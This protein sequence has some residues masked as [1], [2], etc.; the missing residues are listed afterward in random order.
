MA[1][2][3]SHNERAA[4]TWGSGGQHYERLS[5]SVSDALTHV[6]NHIAPQPDERF[7][8]VATGTGLTARLLASRGATVTGTDFAAGLIEA[9][10]AL[11]PPIDFQIADAEALPF[12][13]SS[14]DAVTSTFGVMFVAQPEIAAREKW[15]VSARK[16]GRL[17]LA[18][19]AAEGTVT[20]LFAIIRSYM[21]PPPANPPPSPFEWG[22]SER[23]RDLLGDAFE[24]RFETGTTTLRMQSGESF[25]DLWVNGFGPAEALAA[26]CDP[27]RR[28]PL[29]RDFIEFHG[30]SRRAN[31]IRAGDL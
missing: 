2:I 25:W 29:K 10:K 31:S 1:V 24:L 23:V 11:A 28:G 17:G 26:S 13:D 9:A 3:L 30:R 15:L 8:D 19:W 12:E 18:T 22:R 16:G 7:L 6:V 27:E 14:F 5:G 21:P 4:A 20:D